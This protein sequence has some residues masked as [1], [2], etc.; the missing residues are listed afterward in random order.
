MSAATGPN[1]IVAAPQPPEDAQRALSDRPGISIRARITLAFLLCFTMMCAVTV[2]GMVFIRDL[3]KKQAFLE[4]AGN[5]IIEVENAR[6]FEKNVL[7]YGTNISDAQD[8]VNRAGSYLQHDSGELEA[9]LGRATL[10]RIRGHLSHYNTALGRLD[11]LQHRGTLKREG[12]EQNIEARLRSYGSQILADAR[13]VVDRERQNM[14]T[15]MRTSRLVSIG[16]LGLMLLLM[17]YIA[18]SLARQIVVPLGRLMKRTERLASG[19]YSPIYPR[20]K[21]RDEITNLAL[22]FN[23][24]LADLK[25]HQGQLIQSRKMAAVGTLTSGVAHEL[26]N[27]LNNIGLTTEALLEEY[28]D[29]SDTDKRAMLEQIYTQVER[30]SATVR[31]LLDFTRKEQTPLVTVQVEELVSRVMELVQNELTLGLV[32]PELDIPSGLPP[33]RGNPRN[34]EQVLLNLSINAIQAMPGGGTLRVAA[35]LA[36]DGFVRLDVSDTGEGIA[37]EHQE[38][39]FDPFFTNKDV[40][41]GTGLGLSVSYSIIQTHGGRITVD[42]EV[43]R[44]TKFSVFLPPAGDEPSR[45][46]QTKG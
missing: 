25:H 5:F 4:K 22:A 41:K 16:A 32:E 1:H 2:G 40:G 30:A 44:G 26:N 11:T 9:V 37:P 20:R 36:D 31:N 33:A 34:L 15:M 23:K 7:L 17:I 27:P 24:M 6:R 19:D 18:S 14:Q 38:K 21:Y 8:H 46:N 3:A 42:S 35:R 12:A 28:D 10:R 13:V 29:Y 43:G 45:A 39:I